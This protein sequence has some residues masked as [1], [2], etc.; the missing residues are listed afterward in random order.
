MVSAQAAGT[1]R[2]AFDE[3]LSADRAFSAASAK[4]DLVAGL[5]A[6]FAADVVMPY[7]PGKLARGAAEAT[8]ALRTSN[9]DSA[10]ATIEWSPAGGGLS[11]DGQHAFTF[12]YMTMRI[13]GAAD[14]PLKYLSYWVKSPGGWRVAA[15]KRARR[16]AGGQA[17]PM[18]PILPSRL[19][20]PATDA[21]TLATYRASL[22]RAERAFSDE[23]QKIGLG[24]AFAK[25]GSADAINL[26]GPGDAQVIVGAEAIGRSVGGGAPQPVSPVSWAPDAGVIVASS[27]DLGVTIGWIRRNAPGPDGTM[28]AP[29]PFFTIWRRATTDAPWRYV[30]E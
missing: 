28:P 8:D 17:T 29:T 18:T 24:P 4:T 23:A 11:A 16:G 2:A 14:Q 15:Y 20:A 6:M 27:G 13:P 22:D 26:G 10:R 1:P 12:G 19:V 7:P 9:P 3:V 30:A 21:A 25:H 5:S